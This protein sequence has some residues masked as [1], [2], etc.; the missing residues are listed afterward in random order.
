M[1]V[2]A[3]AIIVAGVAGCGKTTIGRALADRLG[4]PFIEA[5]EFHSPSAKARMMAGKPL[6]DA[7]RAPWLAALNEALLR[8]APAVLACSALKQIYRDR[9][10]SGL[11]A[12][13]VWIRLSRE[14]ATERVA[15]RSDHFM[16]AGLVESQFA[17]AE[18]PR[19]ATFLDA[20]EPVDSAVQYCLESLGSFVAE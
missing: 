7:D 6:D 16:P 13:F 3:K 18:I 20:R 11:S 9:L 4:W 12:Q 17:A 5:D 10:S 14:L 8:Q 19:R 2:T 1:R 15:G